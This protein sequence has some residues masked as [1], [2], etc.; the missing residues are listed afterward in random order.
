MLGLGPLNKNYGVCQGQILLA[1]VCEALRDF[2]KIWSMNQDRPFVWKKPQGATWAGPE[3]GW[4][5]ASENHQGSTNSVC[6]VD[7]DSD[8]AATASAGW[9]RGGLNIGTMASAS[10]LSGESCPSSL[11]PKARQFSSSL[12]VPVPFQAA[13]PM[14]LGLRASESFSE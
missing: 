6:Q 9:E 14:L 10:T 13:S 5:K 3:F 12:Y 2:C 7:G 11:C 1:W 8:M 4:V